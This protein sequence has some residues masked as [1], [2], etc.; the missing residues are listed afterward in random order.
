MQ[1]PFL[2][3]RTYILAYAAAWILITGIHVSVLFF[4]SDQSLLNSLADGLVFN[5]LFA[6]LGLSVWYAVRY[7]DSNRS[8]LLDTILYHL[9][10]AALALALWAGMGYLILKYAF[11][12]FLEYHDFLEESM[13]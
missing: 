4:F 8:H 3:R 10:T 7:Y 6:G 9:G 12:A 11:P 5:I 2:E 13:P 1:N